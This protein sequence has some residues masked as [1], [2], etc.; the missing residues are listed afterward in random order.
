MHEKKTCIEYSSS[1][2]LL[3]AVGF[4][5]HGSEDVDSSCGGS[6]LKQQLLKIFLD[7]FFGGVVASLK[8]WTLRCYV[9]PWVTS[10]PLSH[11]FLEAEWVGQ[12]RLML[13]TL[14]IIK[15]PL[16][17]GIVGTDLQVGEPVQ[18]H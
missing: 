1:Y 17:P 6:L 15:F 12:E 16:L 13:S 2:S 10:W 9:K 4:A 8:T 18:N 7:F 14:T 3:E 5:Q 11:W